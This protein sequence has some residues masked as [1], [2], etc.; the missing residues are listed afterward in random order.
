MIHFQNSAL[1]LSCKGLG[2]LLNLLGAT[3]RYP[4]RGV[5]S[6]PGWISTSRQ[7]NIG[8]AGGVVLRWEERG[9]GLAAAASAV[10]IIMYSFSFVHHVDRP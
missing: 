4:T 5:D 2:D 7:S 3:F 1:V 10:F 9:G 6:N 8:T